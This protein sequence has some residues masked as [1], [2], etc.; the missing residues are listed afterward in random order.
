MSEK[1]FENKFLE[2]L[3]G[4][5]PDESKGAFSLRKDGQS[6]VLR[7]SEKIVITA[8]EDKPGIN[9]VIADNAVEAVHVPVL[10]T[11]TGHQERVYNTF[12]VGDNCNVQII[13]GCGIHNPGEDTS[14]HDGV[15]E[16]IVGDN[17]RVVYTEKHIGKGEGQGKRVMNPKTK[18][19]VGDNSSLIMNMAQMGGIDDAFREAEIDLGA[20]SSVKI[21]ERVMTDGD[22]RTQSK[23]IINMNGTGAS[24]LIE[25][26]SVAKGRSYQAIDTVINAYKPSRGH[27]ECTSILMDEGKVKSVPA[28]NAEDSEA[29]LTHEAAIGKI[30]GEQLIK[31]MSLGLTESEAQEA[32]LEG[33]LK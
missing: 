14:A 9:V 28:L 24:S 19:K 21:Y 30:A 31:L 29:E 23:I 26:R 22:Q 1:D 12:V 6:A 7:S 18:V 16:I 10:L 33:F 11:K 20:N 32:I 3:V 5:T 13:A 8:K 2:E 4:A 27:V 15:H 17:S 25:S